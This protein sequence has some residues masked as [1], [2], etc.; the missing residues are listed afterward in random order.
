ML[1]PIRWLLVLCAFCSFALPSQAQTQSQT[2]TT[3]AGYATLSV[4][5]QLADRTLSVVT[6]PA[7]Y[8]E[9]ASIQ[10]NTRIGGGALVDIGGGVRVWRNLLVGLSFSHYG[11]KGTADVTGQIP[12]PIIIGNFRNATTSVQDLK[13]SE[14]AVNL[15][16]RWPFPVNEKLVVTGIL[17]PSFIKVSQD[18]INNVSLTEGAFP[19]SSVSISSTS[20]DSKSAWGTGINIGIDTTYPIMNALDAGLLLRYVG[21]SPKLTLDSGEEVKAK[22]GGFQIAGGLRYRF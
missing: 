8:G 15:E 20:V 12:N 5:G 16:L 4:G 9:P 7:I 2:Q 18:V 13:R 1:N 17:G 6:S 10:S 19:F 3:P 11:D 14:N 21:A 22:A